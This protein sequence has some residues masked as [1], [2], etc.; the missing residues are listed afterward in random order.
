MVYSEKR[1]NKYNEEKSDI[2]ARKRKNI[3]KYSGMLFR[4]VQFAKTIELRKIFPV[5]W[6]LKKT[7]RYL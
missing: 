7:L 5:I 3:K 4:V 6:E 1:G 2:M